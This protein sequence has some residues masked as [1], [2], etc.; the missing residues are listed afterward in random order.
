[1]TIKRHGPAQTA[2]A[3]DSY[4]VEAAATITPGE[5]MEQ[6]MIKG[7]LAK[8][9]PEE[10]ARYYTRVCESVGINPLTRPLEYITL[11][12]KL[13]L[14]ARKD[15]TDQLRKLHGVSVEE[16]LV[17]ELGPDIYVFVCKVRD[18]DGRTD[19]ARGAVNI[20]GLKG[21]ALANQIMKGETKSKRRATLSI[22]GMGFLDETEVEDIPRAEKTAKVVG[23]D[24]NGRK[25]AYA[26]KKDGTDEFYN[27]LIEKIRDCPECEALAE[28]RDAHAQEIADL[29]LRWV[30]LA[31]QEYETK[32]VE[33][34]GTSGECPW[35][36]MEDRL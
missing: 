13:T 34:G 32:W 20:A 10:R 25:T 8:L 18:R 12:G 35:P 22:A 31:S 7:D 16:V 36:A 26:A 19:I 30:I 9:T 4:P 27:A 28:L 21:E 5:I 3:N 11:N 29:P 23:R 1:M 6:V 14:Y 33:L 15:C 2:S 24:S 17:E